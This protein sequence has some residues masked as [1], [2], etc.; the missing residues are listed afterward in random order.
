MISRRFLFL[1][2]LVT[3]AACF[4]LL[5]V[6]HARTDDAEER[7][8]YDAKLDAIRAE[9]RDE[10]G[11]GHLELTPAGRGHIEEWQ[12]FQ[13]QLSEEVVAPLK[14]AERRQL[15]KLLERILAQAAEGVAITTTTI[16]GA[17]GDRAVEAAHR[18]ARLVAAA[19]GPDRLA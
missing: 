4:F 9:V 12:A 19:Q 6:F 18:A 17:P 15:I 13:R 16:G 8:T 7:A 3:T 11:R 14:P 10:L 1:I 2:A 5:G